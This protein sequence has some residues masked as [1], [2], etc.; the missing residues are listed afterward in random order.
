MGKVVLRLREEKVEMSPVSDHVTGSPT[1]DETATGDNFGRCE[2]V[3]QRRES[4]T[5]LIE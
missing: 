5:E 3:P 1:L 4:R 2:H